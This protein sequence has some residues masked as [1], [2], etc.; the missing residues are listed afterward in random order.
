MYND[1]L[2][3]ENVQWRLAD[4]KTWTRVVGE[5]RIDRE[6]R[7]VG[8]CK[9]NCIKCV[10]NLPF[11]LFLTFFIG[12]RV[13][14]QVNCKEWYLAEIVCT[15]YVCTTLVTK[16]TWSFSAIDFTIRVSFKYIYIYLRIHWFNYSN[17]YWF[18]CSLCIRIFRGFFC[19]VFAN[20]S[21][22]SCCF[23]SCF[24]FMSVYYLGG[25]FSHCRHLSY[26]FNISCFCSC[27]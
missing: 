1:D 5:V 23:N 14:R 3:I 13:L 2:L 19:F 6:K 27:L 10:F 20:V 9:L 18:I 17:N 7:T 15:H 16:V 25:V 4:D 21:V 12:L 26:P 22:T 11:I 24:S 8:L